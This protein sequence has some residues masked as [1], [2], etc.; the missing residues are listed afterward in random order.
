MVLP[1]SLP[2]SLSRSLFPSESLPVLPLTR[3]AAAMLPAQCESRTLPLS[4]SGHR[5]NAQVGP[6]GADIKGAGSI[7]VSVHGQVS[8]CPRSQLCLPLRAPA[9]LISK[10]RGHFLLVFP[11]IKSPTSRQVRKGILVR[12]RRRCMQL[13]GAHIWRPCVHGAYTCTLTAANQ[14]MC[15]F[16]QQTHSA[17]HNHSTHAHSQSMHTHTCTTIAHMYTYT[18]NTLSLAHTQL[19]SST[20][21]PF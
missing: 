16:T 4:G 8:V 6:S 19:G 13:R 15:T 5:A 1:P 11:G 10:G 7:S 18:A 21:G 20:E 9:A 12:P 14:S 3:K 2:P 17:M